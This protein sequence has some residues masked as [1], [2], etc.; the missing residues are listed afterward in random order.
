MVGPLHRLRLSLA[1]RLADF[2]LP[3][4]FDARLGPAGG[5]AMPMPRSCKRAK[6][7]KLQI[8]LARGSAFST[9]AT[10]QTSS[11]RQRRLSAMATN[12]TVG[13]GWSSD[14]LVL[15]R[16]R[17]SAASRTRSGRRRADG[18]GDPDAADAVAAHPVLDDA[19]DE[20]RIRHDHGRAVEGLD[21]GRAHVDAPHMAL[22][23]ADRR[24]SRRRGSRAP[25]AGS[26]PRRN[27]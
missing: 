1:A 22:V 4:Q 3:R 24:S 6:I 17:R 14:E 16:D 10:K 26:G 9:S 19:G 15:V 18:D 12:S 25:T 8:A 27:C 23:V 11:K 13:A 21:L 7:A 20:V 5:G 2:L